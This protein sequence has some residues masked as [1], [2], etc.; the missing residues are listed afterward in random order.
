[1]SHTKNDLQD[2]YWL[3][4][5]LGRLQ[6]HFA[7]VLMDWYPE[8][9]YTYSDLKENQNLVHDTCE[10]IRKILGLPSYVYKSTDS[11]K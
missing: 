3:E 2:I 7:D 8:R 9:P 11:K 5:Y 1:M 10:S 4:M 6:Q